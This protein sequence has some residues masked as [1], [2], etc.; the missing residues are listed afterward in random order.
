[1]VKCTFMSS[2]ELKKKVNW[3]MTWHETWERL[4]WSGFVAPERFS[5]QIEPKWR[6]ERASERQ[7]GTWTATLHVTW[8]KK[9][10]Q[11]QGRIKCIKWYIKQFKCKR[12]CC[13]RTQTHST[14][15]LLF[16]MWRLRACKWNRSAA[17]DGIRHDALSLEK[18]NRLSAYTEPR[19]WMNGNPNYTKITSS[20]RLTS[21]VR[22]ESS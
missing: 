17:S 3:E 8:S 20:E 7:H 6:N 19:K 16:V 4:I 12:K 13:K 18:T 2:R 5:C 22:D 15:C 10:N 21:Q 9:R 1:M 14:W 11:H